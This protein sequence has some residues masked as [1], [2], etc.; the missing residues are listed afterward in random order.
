MPP[1]QDAALA[2]ERA[3]SPARVLTSPRMLA[4]H[5][6]GAVAVGV[7]LTAGVWQ[8]TAWEDRRAAEARDLTSAEPR[9][10]DAV[11]DGDDPFPGE[12]VG[13]PVQLE[14]SWRPAETFFVADREDGREESGRTGYWIVTPLDVDGNDSAVPVVRGW[15]ADP[16][17]PA[18]PTPDAEPV[19]LTGWLQ[20]SEGR[21]LADDDPGDDVLPELRI[22]SLTQ[23]VGMDLYSAFVVADADRT[24]DPAVASAA[25]A[26]ADL[27]PVRPDDLPDVGVFTALRNL[28]YAGEWWVFAVFA[29][30]IWWRFCRDELLA[31]RRRTTADD[32]IGSP[33]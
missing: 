6:L 23:R 1:G 5:L 8:Y 21:G 27:V 14:G 15:V 18:P 16:T 2:D 10:L 9:P 20:P 33:A 24:D 12:L 11:M 25:D 26:G 3:S 13:L 31:A 30:F 19:A 29:A 22:A 17:D 7:A 4:V 32:P 28:L